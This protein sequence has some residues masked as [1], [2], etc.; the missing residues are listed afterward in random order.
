[1]M[2]AEGYPEEIEDTIRQARAANARIEASQRRIEELEVA[3]HADDNEQA[4]AMGWLEANMDAE[5]FNDA[6]G[7]YPRQARPGRMEKS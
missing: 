5:D 6:F 7:Y 1:M 2:V 3:I 4:A